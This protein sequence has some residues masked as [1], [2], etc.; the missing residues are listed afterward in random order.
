[1]ATNDLE[2]LIWLSDELD[3]LKKVLRN[4]DNFFRLNFIRLSRKETIKIK[5]YQDLEITLFEKYKNFY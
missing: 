4:D 5:I 2:S 1:M 3:N